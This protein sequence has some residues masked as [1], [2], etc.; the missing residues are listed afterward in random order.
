MQTFYSAC[1][2]TKLFIFKKAVKIMDF[3]NVL[4]ERHC[5]RK[6]IKKDVSFHK[7][8]SIIESATLAPAAGNIFSVRV[9]IIKDSKLKEMLADAAL[10]QQF[11]TEAPY[12]LIVCS[13]L[14]QVERSYGKIAEK[15]ARQQAG[16]AIEN[17]FLKITELGL[18]TCWVGGFEENMIKRALK[19]P[20]NVNVEAL[21]P[22]GY[23]IEKKLKKHA[24]RRKMDIK[25][26]VFFDGYG[27]AKRYSEKEPQ[28][29][30]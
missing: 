5:A 27:L 16:A 19:I 15:F 29:E 18:N 21:L 2:N 17:M 30:V 25:H 10:G 26:M 24:E 23:S 3:D 13:D 14:E 6:F 12:V 22:I 8:I 7:I 4:K 11:L 28:F 1:L 9:I 20:D